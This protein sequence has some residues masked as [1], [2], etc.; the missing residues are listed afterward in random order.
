[1]VK[2]T[3]IDREET[4]CHHMGYYFR[5]A[6]RVLLYVPSHRQD[7]HGLCYTSH[8]LEWEIAQWDKNT[9]IL[10]CYSHIYIE[11]ITIVSLGIGSIMY[12]E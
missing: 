6:A 2:D 1:M 8:W 4:R 3:Q 9:V 10:K 12:W 11:I 7:N 5:L